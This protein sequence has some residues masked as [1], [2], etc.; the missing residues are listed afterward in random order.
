MYEYRKI[1]S[2]SVDRL[3]KFLMIDKIKSYDNFGVF[4]QQVLSVA[5]NEINKYSDI[6]ITY[7]VS[8]KEVRKIT[9]LT[10]FIKRKDNGQQPHNVLT[11][12]AE[13]PDRS[14]DISFLDG[15]GLLD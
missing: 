13:E 15:I 14:Y 8:G 6:T 11:D 4:K 3:K 2:V 7:E 5:I 10:F 12:K 9:E 1:V